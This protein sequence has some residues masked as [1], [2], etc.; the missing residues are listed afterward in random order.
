MIIKLTR[1][2]R[3]AIII[4]SAIFVIFV[5]SVPRTS[6]IATPQ[7]NDEVVPA[8][9][10]A[11]RDVYKKG[12]HTITGSMLAPNACTFVNAESTLIGDESKPSGINLIL[13]ISGDDGVCLQV[14]TTIT[15]SV[16]VKAPSGLPISATL[17]GVIASTT[18]L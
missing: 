4:A 9:S 11:L 10:V 16:S 2:S 3:A 6:E 17:N 18:P 15:F 12:V 13:T 5:F 7:K 8:P 14:P 1:L